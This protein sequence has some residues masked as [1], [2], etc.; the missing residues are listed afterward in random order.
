MNDQGNQGSGPHKAAPAKL[1]P[2]NSR[3]EDKH[4][5][6]HGGHGEEEKPQKGVAGHAAG[7]RKEL[8]EEEEYNPLKMPPDW[9]LAENHAK[10]RSTAPDKK[11]D[12]NSEKVETCPCCGF[13]IER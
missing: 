8:N 4:Q 13:E 5:G 10:A 2:N 9:K 1:S 12:G 11:K 7:H 3:I 6:G